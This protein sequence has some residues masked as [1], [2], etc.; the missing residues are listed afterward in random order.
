MSQTPARARGPRQTA[1][2]KPRRAA[3]GRAAA[4][5]APAVERTRLTDLDRRLIAELQRDAREPMSQIAQRLQVAE[6]T[7]R[8]RV[9]R[10]VDDGLIEFMAVTD[11][12]RLGY[13][14]MVFMTLRVELDRLRDVAER[15]RA[16]PHT[17]FVGICTGGVDLLVGAAFRSKQALLEFVTGELASIPGVLA[18]NTSNILEVV[19]RTSAFGLI[20][21]DP[22]SA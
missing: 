19:K 13:Q 4:S 7:V 2:G 14:E 22:P 20:L 21:E 1:G 15:L 16:L 5:R 17:F 12:L 3:P 6:S 18:A 8:H 9:N 10:L 11:P